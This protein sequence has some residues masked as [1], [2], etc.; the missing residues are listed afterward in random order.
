MIAKILQV[1]EYM[2]LCSMSICF[3]SCVLAP[4]SITC[5]GNIRFVWRNASFFGQRE[6]PFQR[7]NIRRRSTKWLISADSP[8]ASSATIIADSKNRHVAV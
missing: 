5:N 4:V 7:D 3:C 6:L 2:I 8:T 1:I